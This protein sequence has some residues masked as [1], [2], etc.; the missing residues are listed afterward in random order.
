M[1]AI[2]FGPFVGDFKSEIL[3][4][5]PYTRWIS[6][7]LDVENIFLFTHFNRD[8]LYDWIQKENIFPIYYHLTREELNQVGYQHKDVK[9]RDFNLML[10]IFK[11]KIIEKTGYNR[12][13]IELYH[14]DYIKNPLFKPLHQKIFTKIKIPNIE[15]P[16]EYKNCVIFIPYGIE[17]VGKSRMLHE[18]LYQNYNALVVG[19]LEISL[20]WD[21]IILN[22]IDYFEIGYKLIFKI[23]SEA[24]LII[25]TTSYWTFLCNLQGWPVFSYGPSPGPY[26]K[27][28]IYYFDNKKSMI[29]SADEGTAVKSIISMIEYFINRIETEK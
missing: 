10:K 13:D 4:F 12:K 20:T 1:K 2:G 5:R 19:N 26:R 18:F 29:M 14:L 15:I 17:N 8:F 6:E 7:V 27:G 22:H 21:N 9:Q 23:L 28:G 11:E 24:K 16:E 25:C 3:S